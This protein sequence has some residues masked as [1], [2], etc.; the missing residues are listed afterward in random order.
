MVEQSVTHHDHIT[1]AINANAFKAWDPPA[2]AQTNQL[3]DTLNG[4]K[5]TDRAQ[6][7]NMNLMSYYG[8]MPVGQLN[9]LMDAQDRIR[10]NDATEAAKHTSLQSSI[11]AV[12]D[13]TTLAAASVESPF[14]KRTSLRPSRPSSKNGMDS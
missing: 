4:L 13:L 1:N 5:D 2:T 10:K 12:N 14:Y 3:C 6:F 9:R 11:S 8:G 7:T